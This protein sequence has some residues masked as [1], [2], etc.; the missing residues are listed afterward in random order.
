MSPTYIPA[1]EIPMI[2]A[3]EAVVSA[4]STLQQL[5]VN[6]TPFPTVLDNTMRS[7]YAKCPHYYFRSFIQ[8][9]RI[10]GTSIHLHAGGA[11]AAA[12]EGWRKAYWE[13]GLPAM[14]AERAGLQALYDYYTAIDAE[15]IEP[16][17]NGDNSLSML[18]LS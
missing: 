6:G 16:A 13:R 14:E 10:K 18:V 5:A 9:L 4:L 1:P 3:A 17:R 7:A 8:N 12:M 15:A 11:F 2:S